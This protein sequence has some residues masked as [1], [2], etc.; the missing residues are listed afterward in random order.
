MYQCPRCGAMSLEPECEW[1]GPFEDK[2]KT[3]KELYEI[4]GFESLRQDENEQV[5][6]AD[7]KKPGAA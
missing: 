4:Y 6:E 5:T 3:I 2:P 1:C 7:P